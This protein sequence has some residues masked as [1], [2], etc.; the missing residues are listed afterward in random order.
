MPIG[1][2]G[3]R[4]LRYV[5]ASV[6][7]CGGERRGVWRGLGVEEPDA[8]CIV[9]SLD[10]IKLENQVVL[11]NDVYENSQTDS[12]HLDIGADRYGSMSGRSGVRVVG[13]HDVSGL[14]KAGWLAFNKEGDAR[15]KDLAWVYICI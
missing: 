14:M 11:T 6:A 9:L 8:M 2:I 3:I 7:F 15:E 13:L 1:N 10:W 12:S 5:R 4:C